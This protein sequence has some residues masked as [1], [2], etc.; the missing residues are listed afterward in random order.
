MKMIIFTIFI[1]RQLIRDKWTYGATPLTCRSING[2]LF[3]EVSGFKCNENKTYYMSSYVSSEFSAYNDYKGYQDN[4]DITYIH[5]PNDDSPLAVF[6]IIEWDPVTKQV[7][8]ANTAATNYFYLVMMFFPKNIIPNDDRC[9]YFAMPYSTM[10]KDNVAQPNYD[11]G[12]WLLCDDVLCHD[13][14]DHN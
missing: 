13:D 5:R 9:G 4:S 12:M 2:T 11:K 6:R 10:A 1:H 14:D 7:R 8:V 3:S